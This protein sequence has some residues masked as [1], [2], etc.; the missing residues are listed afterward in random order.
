MGHLLICYR[1]VCSCF[2][3]LAVYLCDTHVLYTGRQLSVGKRSCA[4]LAELDVRCCIKLT[5]FPEMLYIARPFVY[6]AAAFKYERPCSRF[7]EYER[8]K[9]AARTET[10]YNRT[11]PDRRR[12]LQQRYVVRCIRRLR[13]IYTFHFCSL[14]QKRLLIFGLKV[15][16]I[17]ELYIRLFARVYR[18]LY[19]TPAFQVELLYSERL[20]YVHRK[21]VNRLIYIKLYL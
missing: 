4:A 6:S 8:C 10:Y 2:Y 14:R 15:Y 13:Q 16:S 12:C 11:L 7:S 20:S 5:C 3:K 1:R 21:S 19:Y 18:L 9:H 17:Y